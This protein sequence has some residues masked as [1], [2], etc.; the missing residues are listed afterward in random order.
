MENLPPPVP[1]ARDGFQESDLDLAY[2]GRDFWGFLVYD[3]VEYSPDEIKE[4]AGHLMEAHRAISHRLDM[5][6]TEVASTLGDGWSGQSRTAFDDTLAAMHQ[7]LNVYAEWVDRAATFLIDL[8]DGVVDDDHNQ[9]IAIRA[10][11]PEF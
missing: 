4:S 10:I 9:A 7:R 2:N 8:A 11:T 1:E 5:L 3:L 6:L